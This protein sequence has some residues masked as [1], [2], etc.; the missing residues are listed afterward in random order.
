MTARRA[1][2]EVDPGPGRHRPARADGLAHHAAAAPGA[3]LDV[4]DLAD[5]AAAR[6]ERQLGRLDL[7]AAQLRDDAARGACGRARRAR[8]AVV[9]AGARVAVARARAVRG[10]RGAR[11]VAGAPVLGE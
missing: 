1:D 4:L 11:G 3:L 7:G 9:G 5:P 10:R 8:G 6:P 2:A